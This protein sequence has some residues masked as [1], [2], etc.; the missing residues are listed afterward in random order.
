MSDLWLGLLLSVPIAVAVN[1]GTP[2]INKALVHVSRRYR[3]RR[4]LLDIALTTW[5]KDLAQNLSAFQ[6]YSAL[7]AARVRLTSMFVVLFLVAGLAFPAAV[8]VM[9]PGGELGAV[10]RDAAPGLGI[11]MLLSSQHALFTLRRELAQ[12]RRVSLIVSRTLG[13]PDV[14]GPSAIRAALSSDRADAGHPV[15]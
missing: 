15:A 8:M 10:L 9:P 2:W 11:L 13:W 6:E 4:H 7:H 12:R 14:S 1:L 5:A 3:L